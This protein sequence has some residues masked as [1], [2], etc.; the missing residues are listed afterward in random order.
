MAT[1]KLKA[2]E[3]KEL[4]SL[5]KERFEANPKRHK[6]V[7]WGVVE[8][9][10]KANETK[11]WSLREMERTGGEPDVVSVD[12][13]TGEVLFIDCAPESPEGRRSLC[14]DKAA[15]LSR[16]ANAPEG[17][18]VSM[19]TAMGTELL[20]EKTYMA[21]QKLGDFDTKTSSWLSTPGSVRA[22]GGALFGDCRYDAVFIYHNGADSYYAARGFRVMLRV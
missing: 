2:G 21:L 19:A 4:L 1:K 10:L 16:K 12:K 17:D 9:K 13:K 6:G 15:L 14:F 11:L 8:A 3:K 22:L 5:L 7:A 18:A 20:D